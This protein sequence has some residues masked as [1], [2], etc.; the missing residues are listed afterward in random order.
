MSL[1][2]ISNGEISAT[3]DS[4]GA[5]FHSIK[6]GE[7]E[8]LW[9]GD[10][11]YWKRR[12]ANLF[13]YVGR[14]TDGV[15]LYKGIKYPLPTHG[16]CIGTEFETEYVSDDKVSFVLRSNDSTRVPYPFEHEF[17]VEYALDGGSIIKT[18]RVVNLDEKQMFFGLGGHPGFNVPLDGSGE[19]TDWYLEFDEPCSPSRIDMDPANYRLAGTERPFELED[20]RRLRL[21]HSLFDL[22]AVVLKD[23]PRAITLRSAVSG[24]SVRVEFP[25]MGFLG[26]W[27]APGTDAGYVCI[28][29]WVTLP[30]HSAYIEDI[31]KQEHMISLPA[32]GEYRNVM[33]VSVS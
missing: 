20:G 14:L 33:T 24:H 28:E 26:L 32:G 25:G 6:K 3:L 4:C 27:H 9:Q 7:T 30:S 15:Y 2:T 21:Q 29:P 10:P 18:C 5:V 12:D 19:F 16:F 23:I 8:Y 31:E 1:I 22:D 13:P 17:H 11:K